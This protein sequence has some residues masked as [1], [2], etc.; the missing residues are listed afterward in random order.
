MYAMRKEQLFIQ[1]ILGLLPQAVCHLPGTNQNFF[2]LWVPTSIVTSI[3]LCKMKS[4]LIWRQW[5]ACPDSHCANHKEGLP[6]QRRRMD[7]SQGKVIQILTVWVI[8]RNYYSIYGANH[9]F[10]SRIPGFA[11]YRVKLPAPNKFQQYTLNF[12]G[13]FRKLLCILTS[14]SILQQASNFLRNSLN[15]AA[16]SEPHSACAQNLL[17]VNFQHCQAQFCSRLP[18]SNDIARPGSPFSWLE[19]GS[20]PPS[21]KPPSLPSYAG[22]VWSDKGGWREWEE[23]WSVRGLDNSPNFGRKFNCGAA[24]RCGF[25]PQWGGGR[26]WKSQPTQCSRAV[27]QP[28]IYLGRAVGGGQG[29]GGFFR[30]GAC[31]DSDWGS[32]LPPFV[33]SPDLGWC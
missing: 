20:S 11:N 3:R 22:S 4:P 32:V 26:S 1:A 15:R 27:E 29:G 21:I 19:L 12:R 17:S 13:V 30:S 23:E 25:L 31:Q 7:Q 14:S 33:P 2:P 18:A 10:L 28:H 9:P 24:H 8:C 5:S 16:N 6:L